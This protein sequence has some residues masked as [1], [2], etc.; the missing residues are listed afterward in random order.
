MVH[1]IAVIPGIWAEVSC[2]AVAFKCLDLLPW[3][4]ELPDRPLL[5]ALWQLRSLCCTVS[6]QLAALERYKIVQ[7]CLS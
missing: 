7:Y 2:S 1:L 4:V 5:L 6:F 3:R